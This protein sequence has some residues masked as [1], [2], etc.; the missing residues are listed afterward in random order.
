MQV[1]SSGRGGRGPLIIMWALI[2]AIL[3]LPAI[4][5]QFT[6]EVAWTGSDF[7]TA[8]SLLV[9]GGLLYQFARALPLKAPYKAGIGLF[10]LGIVTLIWADGAVGIF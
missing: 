6:R 10:L 9:G 4:A 3:L 5:M 8:A 2:A 1:H 7:A